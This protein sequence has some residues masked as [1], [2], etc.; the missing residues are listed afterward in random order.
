MYAQWVF[1][2]RDL[3]E[4]CHSPHARRRRMQKQSLHLKLAM[5]VLT[6]TCSMLLSPGVAADKPK[7][8]TDKLVDCIL[9][10]QDDQKIGKMKL[11]LARDHARLDAMN[12]LLHVVSSAPDWDV[13]CWNHDKQSF[14]ISQREWHE[15][16]IE[17]LSASN[18]KLFD[19]P[20]NPPQKLTF[21]GMPA[22]K[23]SRI[24]HTGSGYVGSFYRSSSEKRQPT[25]MTFIA[26]AHLKL[27]RGAAAFCEGLYLTT[28]NSSVV[29]EAQSK[30][31]GQPAKTSLKTNSITNVKKPVAFFSAPTQ[32]LR[33]AP[34]LA[35]VVAGKGIE[36][37]ML[38]F[39]GSK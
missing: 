9:I 23:N 39:S 2:R 36:E 17:S 31:V 22:L 1:L 18:R 25:R 13:H 4:A 28:P 8:A 14:S 11:Y 30:A 32:G 26:T 3:I 27:S 21:M 5:A 29:L 33:P 10:D 37:M 38:N 16:G 7:A 6:A 20:N 19:D 12:G 24:S 34:S 35:A 15:S